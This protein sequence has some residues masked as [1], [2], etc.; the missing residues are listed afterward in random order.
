[1][2]MNATGKSKGQWIFHGSFDRTVDYLSNH[3]RILRYNP[4]CHKIEPLDHDDAWRW[5]FRVTDPQQ[6]PFD[7]IFNIRQEAEILIDIPDE[8]SSIPPEEMTD[9][10]IRQYTVGRKIHWRHMPA[11]Q[12]IAMPE[13]YLFEGKVNADL[14]ILPVKKE[15]TKVDFDLRVDVSFLLYPAFRIVPE[16]V[17]RTMVSTGMSLIMQTATNSMF[18]KISKDFG[19]IRKL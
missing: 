11:S 4:F 10:M 16:K 15:R 2:E 13:K 17:V 6:N 7:V 5:H 12:T 8:M 18:Q 1:M 14:L 3:S 19:T 9:E